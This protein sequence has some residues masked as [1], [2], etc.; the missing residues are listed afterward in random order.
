[1][2]LP[3]SLAALRRA[4]LL[5]PRYQQLRELLVMS[6]S[7]ESCA[8]QGNWSEAL[9]RQRERRRAM[10]DFFSQAC[11]EAEAVLVAQVIQH[12]LHIDDGLTRALAERRNTLDDQRRQNQRQLGQLEHY[13]QAY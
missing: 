3:T 6:E 10:E 11:E 2:S 4:E 9:A 13:L 5:K 7:V 12:I 8:K 1:M